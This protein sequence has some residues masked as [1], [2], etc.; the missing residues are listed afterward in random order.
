[1]YCSN[2]TCFGIG[3]GEGEDVIK[4][5]PYGHRAGIPLLTQQPMVLLHK[6]IP[7]MLLEP[8][9]SYGLDIFI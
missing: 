1:M 8:L 9:H 7:E 4:N 6:I 2:E 5:N 3:L